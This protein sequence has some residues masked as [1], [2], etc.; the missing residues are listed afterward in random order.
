MQRD[1]RK[2]R[3]LDI[4]FCLTEETSD[5]G[6]EE[7]SHASGGAVGAVSGTE[8]IVNVHVEGS[9]ELLGELLVVLLLCQVQSSVIFHLVQVNLLDNKLLEF[10]VQINRQESLNTGI[11]IL[12][13]IVRKQRC[14]C[15]VL[16][17]YVKM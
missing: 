13:R 2:N 11:Q 5:G 1:V 17:T 14:A 4:I 10:T 7:L 16:G 15:F 6:L 8:S 3:C 12:Q 9:G